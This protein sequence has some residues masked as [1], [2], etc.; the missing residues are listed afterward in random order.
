M[1]KRENIF[2]GL[3]PL[4][5]ALCGY[6]Y[7]PVLK[8]VVPSNVVLAWMPV[9]VAFLLSGVLLVVGM[10]WTV[11]AFRRGQPRQAAALLLGTLLGGVPALGF[12]WMF[13]MV[14]FGL[15]SIHQ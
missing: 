10:R 4:P 3:T 9:N 7:L 15:F 8:W 12:L 1:T 2:L 13:G 11:R 6:A 14:T 5:V